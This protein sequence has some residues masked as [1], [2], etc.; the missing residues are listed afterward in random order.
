LAKS[1]LSLFV[2]ASSLFFTH[3][4][5]SSSFKLFLF[6]KA[7]S[8]LFFGHIHHYVHAYAGPAKKKKGNACSDY[9]SESRSSNDF[10]Q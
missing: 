1:W 8:L 3:L 2:Q 5:P 4:Y 9:E 7:S 10:K 6:V